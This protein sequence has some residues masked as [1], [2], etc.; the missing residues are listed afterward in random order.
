MDETGFRIRVLEGG[1]LIVVRKNVQAAFMESPEKRTLVTSCETVLAVGDSI[2][3]RVIFP[4]KVH[5]P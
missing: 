2:P 1:Q 5:V 3:P 4:A